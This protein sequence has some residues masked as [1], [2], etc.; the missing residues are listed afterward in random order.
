MNCPN[1]ITIRTLEKYLNDAYSIHCNA[2]PDS[3]YHIPKLLSYLN[4]FPFQVVT[5]VTIYL[6]CSPI[7]VESNTN[8]IMQWLNDIESYIVDTYKIESA[9]INRW[10]IT[11]FFSN[12]ADALR[13]A[14]LQDGDLKTYE[15]H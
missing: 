6:R 4:T 15:T 1:I 12:E 13:F 11:V 7:N 8:N 5:V 9:T 2:P 3:R 10:S 14:W